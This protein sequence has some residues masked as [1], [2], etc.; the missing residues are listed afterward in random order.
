VKAED[1]KKDKNALYEIVEDFHMEDE[2][3]K[4][5]ATLQTHNFEVSDTLVNNK[6]KFTAVENTYTHSQSQ[7]MNNETFMN[8]TGKTMMTN[9]N[10][11][12]I[13]NINHPKYNFESSYTVNTQVNELNNKTNSTYSFNINNPNI[14]TKRNDCVTEKFCFSIC[15][16]I[17]QGT[18]LK[19]VERNI[20]LFDKTYHIEDPNELMRLLR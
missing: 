19:T 14:Q 9:L 4:I 8:E 17:N 1:E 2:S 20:E 11:L 16:N 3:S 7:L 5:D 12:N 18:S 13:S 15:Q 6:D 10:N